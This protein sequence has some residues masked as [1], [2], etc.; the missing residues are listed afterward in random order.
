MSPLVGEVV[1]VEAVGRAVDAAGAGPIVNRDGRDASVGRGGSLTVPVTS[2]G[3]G[4]VLGAPL[5]FPPS[6][7]VPLLGNARCEARRIR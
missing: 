4:S 7:R 5:L 2:G 6:A 1:V 3:S